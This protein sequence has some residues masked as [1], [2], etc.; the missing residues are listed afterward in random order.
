MP[1]YPYRGLD[2]GRKTMRNQGI[3]AS[4]R[5]WQGKGAAW[6]LSASLR[7]CA[8]YAFALSEW[9]PRRGS[10][11]SRAEGSTTPRCAAFSPPCGP[12]P[13]SRSAWALGW[14]VPEPAKRAASS[15]YC[16][17]RLAVAALPRRYAEGLR[18]FGPRIALFPSSSPRR[19]LS[20]RRGEEEVGRREG[21]PGRRSRPAQQVAKPQIVGPLS[22]PIL[23]TGGI[24]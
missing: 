11:R 21:V 22:S 2:C 7:L 23:D 6:L 4:K 9:S 15:Q 10:P 16:A 12:L 17:K 20:L 3:E 19:R 14:A 8:R 18:P 1:P 24:V 13:G 5:S